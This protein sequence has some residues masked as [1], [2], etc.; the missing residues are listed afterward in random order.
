MKRAR[1]ITHSGSFHADDVFGV[2]CVLILLKDE[3]APPEI[4]RSREPAVY[5]G[6]DYVVDVGG[7]YNE[8]RD[9]FDHHQIG[10][11]GVRGNGIPYASFGLVWKKYGTVLAGSSEAAARVEESLVIPID[12][13]DNGVPLVEAR[14]GRFFPYLIQDAIS[15]LE[16][17]W[18]ENGG[19]VDDA[20]L[21]ALSFARKILEREIAHARDG[22]EGDTAVRGAYEAARDRRLVVLSKNYDWQDVLASKPEPL[23]V[24]EPERGA[25]GGWKVSA[26]RIDPR[27][28]ECRLLLPSPWAGKRDEELRVA[29]GVS[30]AVFC[31]NQR[32]V[33]VARSKEGALALAKQALGK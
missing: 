11:A 12:A 16:P 31:H 25:R 23:F 28:F 27:S 2:A 26:V 9:R 20:F 1:I 33:A 14:T 30:D 10:G 18:R 8:A 7:E 29:T 24:V 4:V 21:E 13:H 22:E 15:S 17:T 32:F 3:P 19:A 5:T 6:G